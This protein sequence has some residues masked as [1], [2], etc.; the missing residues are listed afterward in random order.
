MGRKRE[1]EKSRSFSCS[2]INELSE[3]GAGKEGA[4]LGI[5]S[6]WRVMSSFALSHGIPIPNSSICLYKCMKGTSGV[7]SIALCLCY[8][9]ELSF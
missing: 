8:L 7:M 2:L 3:G 4:G 6:I 5:E 1:R 9:A